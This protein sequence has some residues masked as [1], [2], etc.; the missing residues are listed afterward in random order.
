MPTN[1]FLWIALKEVCDEVV[2][3]RKR[4]LCL[5]RGRGLDSALEGN[6]GRITMNRLL[7]RRGHTAAAVPVDL[8][9]VQ[10][11]IIHNE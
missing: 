8:A 7:R 4:L 11:K 9:F 10:I 2:C 6:D 1:E 5:L 3:A